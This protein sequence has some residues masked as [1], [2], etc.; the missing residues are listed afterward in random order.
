MNLP[1]MSSAGLTGVDISCSIVPRSHS[2]ATVSDVKSAAMIIMIIAMSPG[3]M[4]FFDSKSWLNHT[5][6]RKSS[7]LIPGAPAFFKA[8]VMTLVL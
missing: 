3:T 6:G 4:K 5:R 7:V 8:F 2:L 1:I